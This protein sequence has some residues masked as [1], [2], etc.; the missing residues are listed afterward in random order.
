MDGSIP[1]IWQL[2]ANEDIPGLIQ[3]LGDLDPGVRK[4][5]AAALRILDAAQALPALEEA[6]EIE[7]EWQAQDS[8]TAAV[9]FL[10]RGDR[11]LDLI[12]QQN[13]DGL[14]AI[15]LS[16]NEAE[17]MG[18][19]RALGQIGDQRAV[20]PLVSLFQAET[21]SDD[22]RY[23]VAETLIELKSAPTIVSL[24]AG[25]RREEWQIRRNSAAILGQL[26]ATWAAPALADALRD[27]HSLVRR[28]AE[29]ALR[30]LDTPAAHE[31]LREWRELQAAAQRASTVSKRPAPTA[32]ESAP[33]PREQRSP[34][35]A[36][37]N[38]DGDSS[39]VEQVAPAAA[40]PPMQ[41][42]KP[43]PVA[44]HPVPPDNIDDTS[45]VE[46]AAL[47]PT[48]LV[49]NAV[50]QAAAHQQPA[51]VPI[52]PADDE[53]D[54]SWVES[55]VPPPAPARSANTDADQ[56]PPTPHDDGPASWVENVD[57]SISE[58]PTLEFLSPEPEQTP[59]GPDSP[60]T[61]SKPPG[62]QHPMEFPPDYADEIEP[63]PPTT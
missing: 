6:L 24:V 21:T 39:W 50:T 31:A 32:S 58:T 52:V 34:A 27:T 57:P 5:A 7:D 23:V 37:R 11:L 44:A 30:Q 25:L 62:L 15:L 26:K 16:G 38:D 59:F 22:V 36:P 3:A 54:S 56:A 28:T 20:E 29:A 40:P 46:H 63:P 35:Q 8:M 14:L 12:T 42:A 2:Q 19:V 4:R 13:V 41:S 33:P 1:N 60:T 48:D 45:W 51:A 49:P 61:P 43:A 55:V 9:Q 17:V 18:A 53:G 47:P 10:S